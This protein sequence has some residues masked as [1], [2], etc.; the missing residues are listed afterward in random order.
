[1]ANAL[2]TNVIKCF[3][4]AYFKI[5]FC[6]IFKIC[7]YFIAGVIY[8]DGNEKT[9]RLPALKK[10]SQITFTCEPLSLSRV[11]VNIDC[12]GKAVTYDWTVKSR[13]LKF[14]ML[15]SDPSWKVMVE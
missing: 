8:V 12:A 4:I 6:I 15:L 7:D 1:M 14:G 10:G 9:T 11:R 2:L 13:I 3:Y 5:F